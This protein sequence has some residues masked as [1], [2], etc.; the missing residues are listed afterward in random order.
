MYFFILRLQMRIQNQLDRR[1]NMCV[2]ID[3]I[4]RARGRIVFRVIAT[5]DS[6]PRRK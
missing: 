2:T 5:D 6:G 4:F 3:L 1:N